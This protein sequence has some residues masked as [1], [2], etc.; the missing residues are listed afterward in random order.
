MPFAFAHAT[1]SA[2]Q[3]PAAT[4]VNP[5]ACAG[6][7]SPDRRYSTVTSI[8]RFM[9]ALGAKVVAESPWNK[10]RATTNDTASAYH[11]PAGTS[12]NETDGAG[13]WLSSPSSIFSNVTTT[14]SV[15][16]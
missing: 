15:L 9:S 13:V 2:Y 7:L 16:F 14:L 4:S 6:A 5:A 1:A 11:A 10:P 12:V 8:A 3:V